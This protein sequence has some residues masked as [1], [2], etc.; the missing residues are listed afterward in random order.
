MR[1]VGGGL[2]HGEVPSRGG[3]EEGCLGACPVGD[4][5]GG[6][7]AW[8]GRGGGGVGEWGWEV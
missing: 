3:G 5:G 7:I 8:H 6:V 2:C 1:G 4:G